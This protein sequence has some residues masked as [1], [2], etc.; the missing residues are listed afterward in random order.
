MS[1]QLIA[2]DGYATPQPFIWEPNAKVVDKKA[3]VY[4]QNNVCSSQD[5]CS[6]NGV[7]LQ[8]VLVDSQ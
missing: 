5:N 2:I 6:N 4:N 8:D 1:A 7:P 3:Y